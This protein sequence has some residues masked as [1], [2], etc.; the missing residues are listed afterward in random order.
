MAAI[1]NLNNVLAGAEPT[2]M[3]TATIDS[4]EEVAYLRQYA[5]SLPNGDILL[6]VWKNGVAMEEDYGENISLTIGN[7][8]A[9]GVTGIDIFHGFEQKLVTETVEGDLVIHDLLV[10]DY[11]IFI[12]LN[13][14]A[15]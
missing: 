9:D 14:G 13:G 3:I 12:K 6:A 8:S 15:P 11:P 10:K 2:D 4:N 1:R 5:F 7:F